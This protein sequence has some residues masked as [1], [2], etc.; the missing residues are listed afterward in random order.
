VA[1]FA[2]LVRVTHCPRGLVFDLPR[3]LRSP[4]SAAR[5]AVAIS[6]STVLLPVAFV[7][8]AFADDY[9]LLQMTN[10]LGKSPWFGDSVVQTGVAG[11]RPF[12]GL[13][14]EAAFGT[15]GTIDNLRF[16]R[17][18]AMLG[19]VAL[20]LL[21]FN[22]LVR[23]G[24]RTFVASLVA[25][26]VCSLPA[27][28]VFG[29]W[30]A[31]FY[32]PYAAI[33][34]GCASLRAAA[35]VDTNARFD[36]RKVAFAA[37]LLLAALLT[38][39]P[40]AMVFWV[41]LAVAL[42]GHAHETRRAIGMVVAHAVTAVSAL[43]AAYLV[44]QI[45]AQMFEDSAPNAARRRLVRDVPGKVDWFVRQPLKN[46]LNVLDLTPSTWL[47][48]FVA[49]V[50]VLGI[51]LLLRS[52]TER[53][54]VF[55]AIG[56]ALVP[57]TYL[58]NLLIAEEW[59]TYRSQVALSSLLALYASLGVIGLWLAAG[60]LLRQRLTEA[61]LRTAEL[62]ALVGGT[63]AVAAC[64]LIASAHVL[65]LFANPQLAELRMIRAQVATLPED[66]T[67]IGFVN[68]GYRSGM[69]DVVRYD[70][71]GVASS[72]QPWT[73]E[74]A[75]F[76]LLREQGKLDLRARPRVEKLP[77]DTRDVPKEYPVVDVRALLAS[78]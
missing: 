52:R 57:A 38:Y 72:A 54:L 13:L 60:Q 22:A 49:M 18:G 58:P 23:A 32:A 31:L 16:V 44:L 20:A 48:V 29:S 46:S 39:Q 2:W 67:R 63:A 55:A 5:A 61:R 45:G 1:L 10:G 74:P 71:F 65:V 40:A 75:V 6:I 4:R 12:A 73:L 66:A 70:E 42:V 37:A 59:A 19:I 64:A 76:L 34:G 36:R 28:Q 15:A 7:P 47:A 14:I 50:S 62:A 8:F 21:L 11:G 51:G 41:F 24:V 43:A 3:Q 26:L 53:P 30:A 27:F 17:L 33:L 9:P 77:W 68:T 56:L 69:T 35:A 78:S 25:I